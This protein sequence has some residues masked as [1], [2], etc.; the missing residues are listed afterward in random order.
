[1]DQT[2]LEAQLKVWKDLAIS[3]Q[4]L[5][6]TSTDALG[7]DPDCSTFELKEALDRAI[8]RAM[9]ADAT[10]SEAEDR[11]SVAVSAMEQKM[12]ESEKAKDVAEA[13]VA[14]AVAAEEDMKTRMAAARE[15]N[16][17]ELKKATTE[18]A[19]KQKELKAI[20]KALADTPENVVKKLKALKKDKFD[21]ATAR[22]AAESKAR[23]V[24]KEKQEVEAELAE[25]NLTIE[26]G[27][28]LAEAYR[29]LYKTCE[30]IKADDKDMPELD[31]ALLLAIEPESTE[32]EE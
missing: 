8:K 10:I 21:E 13:T 22:K 20:N 16:A 1:M 26:N 6:Q 24:R 25:A 23:E 31:E 28:K 19:T 12:E 11:A 17:K 32:D 15:A 14:A 29:A 7:L 30:E 27:V 3:K 9:E 4:M 18:L 5:I 2:E